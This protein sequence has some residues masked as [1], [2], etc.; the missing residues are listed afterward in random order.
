MFRRRLVL[1]RVRRAP[2]QRLVARVQRA[3]SAVRQV[4]LARAAEPVAWSL[5][6]SVEKADPA[7]VR[8]PEPRQCPAKV[9][10]V[11]RLRLLK[12]VDQVDELVRA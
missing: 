4:R 7:L 10:D 3:R 8:A 5:G 6:L 1:P 12:A 11:C 9:Q 2:R